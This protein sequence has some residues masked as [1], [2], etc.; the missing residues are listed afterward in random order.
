MTRLAPLVLAASLH[1]P[2]QLGPPTPLYVGDPSRWGHVTALVEPQY[3]KRALDAKRTGH[4]DISGRVNAH[5][6]LEQITYS[7]DKPASGVFIDPLRRV[8]REWRFEPPLGRDCQPSARRVANRVRFALEDGKPRIDV[9][10]VAGDTEAPATVE[11]LKRETPSHDLP[12]PAPAVIYARMQVDSHG[13]V[14][15]VEPRSYPRERRARG[16]RELEHEVIRAL[17]QWK[18]PPAAVPG[19]TRHV[20]FPVRLRG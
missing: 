8:I 16:V 5:G 9:S 10:L 18:F 19:A 11:P 1:A 14:V 4:V 15:S 12:G 17:T 2:A 6:V 13:D 20:C 7:P 3:P